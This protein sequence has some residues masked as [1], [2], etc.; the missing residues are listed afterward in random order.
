MHLVDKPE[1]WICPA[2]D[3]GRPGADD[4]GE[5]EYQ[6]R[7]PTFY[8]MTAYRD[9][10]ARAYGPTPRPVDMIGDLV[11]ALDAIEPDETRRAT[12]ASILTRARL[13]PA[14]L[15][16][17]E[18]AE[19]ETL[20]MAEDVALRVSD[21]YRFK[22]ARIATH[23]ELHVIEIVREHVAGWRHMVDRAGAELRPE[24][25]T[26]FDGRSILSAAAVELIPEHHLA[27]LAR[28]IDLLERPTGQAEKNSLSRPS[29]T[30]TPETS[31]TAANS[32]PKTRHKAASAGKSRISRTRT[33]APAA[34]G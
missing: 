4:A 10:F 33:A 28:R 26:A 21:P 18:P 24:F 27:Y 9:R 14:R 16:L 19:I 6:V 7:V 31:K 17:L 2:R 34:S 12:L 5:I 15:S 30:T 13:D 20:T 25:E 22:R 11:N 23:G 1:I 32:R 29:G 8:G 3:T